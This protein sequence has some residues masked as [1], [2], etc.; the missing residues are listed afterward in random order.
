MAIFKPKTGFDKVFE[1]GIILKGLD[2]LIETLGGVL[3]LFVRPDNINRLTKYL[4]QSELSTDPHDFIANHLVHWSAQLTKG[5]LIFGGI[6][7]L[8]HGIAKL[9]L[10]IE[11]FQNRLWA[12]VG[13]ITLTVVFIIYQI[14]Q[15]I[16]S[17]SIGL[18]LLTIF[19]MAIVYLTVREYKKQRLERHSSSETK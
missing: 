5:A 11:I 3:L 6:Y 1:V 8:I 2:G 12:Y 14:Y 9:I 17:H 16:F 4:T 7:L 19:D 18:V 13:L 10:V 15:I